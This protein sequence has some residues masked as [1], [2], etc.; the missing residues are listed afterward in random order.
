MSKH[1]WVFKVILVTGLFYLFNSC[2]KDTNTYSRVPSPPGGPRSGV[3]YDVEYGS[4]KDWLG[5]QTKLTMDVYF[6]KQVSGKKYPLVIFMH[7][8]GFETGD[9]S[10]TADKCSLFADSGFVTATI[11]YRQ[12]WDP[13]A[14]VCDGDT[15]QIIEA[16]YR[17]IQDVNAAARFLIEQATDYNIDTNW[18]FLAGASAGA[19]AMLNTAY[20]TDTYV[21]SRMPYAYRDLGGLTTSG[22]DLTNTFMVQGICSIAGALLDSN[23]I[24]SQKAIPTIFFQGGSDDVVPVDHGTYLYCPNYPELFGSLSLYRQLRRYGEPAVAN[25]YP[26]ATH[27]NNGDSGFDNDF[28]VSRSTCFFH[29]LM[30]AKG[31]IDSGVYLAENYTCP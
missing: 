6:P 29:N 8:G 18:V 14:G 21:K 22:N 28:M 11:N 25:I 24:T 19:V 27:G 12:G 7:G 9:K 20:F 30:R 17:G 1:L 4:A 2:S 5:T 31:N 3:L 16:L 10:T 26:N 13:G 15:S 23:L